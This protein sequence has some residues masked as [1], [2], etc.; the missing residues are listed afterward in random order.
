MVTFAYP[1]SLSIGRPPDRGIDL[2]SMKKKT[3][4]LLLL[5][6]SAF[7]DDDVYVF[8]HDDGTRHL[9]LIGVGLHLQVDTKMRG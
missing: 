4:E 6:R 1:N 2:D 7:D 5:L 8:A 9:Q 3:F